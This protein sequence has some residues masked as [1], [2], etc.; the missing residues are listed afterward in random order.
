MKNEKKHAYSYSKNILFNLQ[1]SLSCLLKLLV[2]GE[3]S[4][5]TKIKINYKKKK[6]NPKS[7]TS[8]KNCKEKIIK[9]L[10]FAL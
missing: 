7:A 2:T 8:C 1:Q 3:I 6:K 5:K 4:L 9:M 10:E